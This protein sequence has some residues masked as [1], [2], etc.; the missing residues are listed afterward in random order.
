MPMMADRLAGLRIEIV[1]AHGE[2]MMSVR[3]KSRHSTPQPD[4]GHAKAG[5][6]APVPKVDIIDQAM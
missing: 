4:S 1:F 6:C 5:D 2:T 3:L